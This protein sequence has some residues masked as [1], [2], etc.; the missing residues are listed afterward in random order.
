M[1]G[2]W[3]LY[4]GVVMSANDPQRRGRL[5]VKV[6]AV[7]GNTVTPWAEACLPASARNAP[8]ATLPAAGTPV[9]IQFEAGDTDNPVWVGFGWK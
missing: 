9:W 2:V 7:L 8:P 5:K 6:P 4:R 3:G 1:Q